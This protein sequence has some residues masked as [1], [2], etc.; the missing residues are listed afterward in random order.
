[1]PNLEDD[2]H[3]NINETLR[4][5]LDSQ[6]LQEVD[7]DKILI[8]GQAIPTSEA[9][10]QESVLGFL[11]EGLIKCSINFSNFD[12]R[13]PI[14][15]GP[16]KYQRKSTLYVIGERRW[17]GLDCFRY[18]INF[19]DYTSLNSCSFRLFKV[20]EIL[21]NSG[22]SLMLSLLRESAHYVNLMGNRNFHSRYPLR[23]QVL[24]WLLYLRRQQKS[25]EIPLS[26][27]DLAQI[28]GTYRSKLNK[29]LK[30][31]ED[32]KLLHCSY[33]NI[34]LP[35]FNTLMK[36]YQ[37]MLYEEGYWDRPEDLEWK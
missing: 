12:N 14:E 3:Q 28:I 16:F 33:R 15:K 24:L 4:Q 26:Q 34:T 32:R 29:T 35:D 13:P 31:L 19:F 20:G 9:N 37:E 27:T 8:Q 18:N 25:P 2:H 11:E 5:F 23:I 7:S 10:I 6:S 21:K 1:M 36:A 30:E 17:F 22:P